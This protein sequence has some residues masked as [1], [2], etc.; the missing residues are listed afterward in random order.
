[1]QKEVRVKIRIL[2][3]GKGLDEI[4]KPS[5]CNPSRRRGF[6]LIE[7]IIVMFIIALG[8][9]LVGIFI[10]GGSGKLELKTFTKNMSATL[11]YARSRAIAE[12]KVYSFII[13]ENK[14]AYGLYAGLPH[15]E[16]IEEA[17]TVAYETIPESLQV[18][19]DSHEN[20]FRINFYPKGNSSGGKIRISNQKGKT[21]FILINKITGSVKVNKNQHTK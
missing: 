6:T 18:M 14:R 1:M 3:A 5:N 8:A 17:V 12:K 21:F 20:Y 4:V 9:G 13:L 15:S 16:D 2:L 11:R 7:L 10:H 19:S